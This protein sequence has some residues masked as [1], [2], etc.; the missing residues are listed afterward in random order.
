NRTKNKCSKD[1]KELPCLHKFHEKCI[2][3]WFKVRSTCPLCRLKV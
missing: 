1:L 3:K 2:E